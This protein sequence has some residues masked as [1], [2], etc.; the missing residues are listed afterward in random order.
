MTDGPSVAPGLSVERE[1]VS[2][3]ELRELGVDTSGASASDFKRYPVLSE[4]GWYIV[5]KNQKTMETV[6]RKKWTLLGPIKL[7]TDGLH[8]A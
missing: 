8:I 4:G 1:D 2:E 6:H 7:V 5:I 3:D